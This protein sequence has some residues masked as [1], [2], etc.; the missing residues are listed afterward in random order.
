VVTTG[1]DGGL[2]IYAEP[3]AEADQTDPELVPNAVPGGRSIDD[4][5]RR[6]MAARQVNDRSRPGHERDQLKAW[7]QYNDRLWAP[8]S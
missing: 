4:Q 1:A 8:R 3:A 5:L 6:R 2:E 7:Q